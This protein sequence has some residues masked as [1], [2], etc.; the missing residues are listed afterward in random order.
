M[1]TID[2]GKNA[3]TKWQS[4]WTSYIETSKRAS[5]SAVITADNFIKR[6]EIARG[7]RIL[8]MGCGHGRITELIVQKVPDLDI[9]AHIDRIV[10]VG[11]LESQRLRVGQG[12]ERHA[13]CKRE[14]NSN[15]A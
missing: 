9:V 8:D 6:A 14:C 4:H 11:E 5:S 15:P 10:V 3:Y 12:R 2:G 7:A 13:R 1:N